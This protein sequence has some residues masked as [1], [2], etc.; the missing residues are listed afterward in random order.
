MSIIQMMD[1]TKSGRLIY[2]VASASIILGIAVGCVFGIGGQFTPTTEASTGL[3]PFIGLFSLF[4]WIWK[5][6]RYI[7][8][9]YAIKKVYAMN[10]LKKVR[11]R[12]ASSLLY[13]KPWESSQKEAYSIE[14]SLRND[15]DRILRGVEFKD[16]IDNYKQAFWFILLT[17]FTFILMLA[18]YQVSPVLLLFG[19]APV[20]FGLGLGGLGIGAILAILMLRENHETPSRTIEFVFA[21]WFHEGAS[22]DLSRRDTGFGMT[23]DV[24]DRLEAALDIVTP[25]TDL[26]IRG[27]WKGF[28]RKS[29]NLSQLIG[30]PNPEQLSWRFVNEFF[31]FLRWAI[32][33]IHG[34]NSQRIDICL[35]NAKLQILDSVNILKE[36]RESSFDQ[37]EEIIE[38]TLEYIAN[39]I[40][41]RDTVLGI[42]V[43]FYKFLNQEVFNNLITQTIE[44]LGESPFRI[45]QEAQLSR[46]KAPARGKELLAWEL[47]GAAE[48]ELLDM[49]QVLT[50]ITGWGVHPTAIKESLGPLTGK[51]IMENDV[52]WSTTEIRTVLPTIAQIMKSV[53]L[54]IM[55]QNFS[56]LAQKEGPNEIRNL[57][58]QLIHDVGNVHGPGLMMEQLQSYLQEL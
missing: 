58:V 53:D 4:L 37:E 1:S 3:V 40:K 18:F 23:S 29:R 14:E 41:D 19:P 24:K 39:S 25:T 43:E 48:R 8:E 54:D 10:D 38:S 30:I 49:Q 56:K 26:V 36:N 51:T 50:I 13:I 22:T 7:V 32:G 2:L 35:Q 17:P 34:P 45:H 12:M 15:I 5:P 52:G 46:S 55:K 6:D 20:V 44:I 31:K 42:K 9:R 21:R 33:E 47:V 57:V 28:D 16:Q 27:D 11:I